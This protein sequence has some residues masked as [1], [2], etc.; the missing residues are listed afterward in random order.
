MPPQNF[1]KL[2]K[3]T[4]IL[5]DCYLHITHFMGSSLYQAQSSTSVDNST[6]TR[7]TSLCATHGKMKMLTTLSNLEKAAFHL[8][9]LLDVSCISILLV[10]VTKI[11]LGEARPASQNQ[12]SRG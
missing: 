6:L 10:H 8:R 2:I 11:S 1:A 4:D 9:Y 12:R 3:W 7:Y 5:D